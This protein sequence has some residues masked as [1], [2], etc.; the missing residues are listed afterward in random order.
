[1]DSSTPKQYVYPV[2]ATPEKCL[3]C[4]HQTPHADELVYC[5]IAGCNCDRTSVAT[6][7]ETPVSEAT[8]Q[9]IPAS[10]VAELLADAAQRY[11]PELER[12]EAEAYAN[13]RWTHDA[14]LRFLPVSEDDG[15]GDSF[16]AMTK[17]REDL[18]ARNAYR[19]GPRRFGRHGIAFFQSRY[20]PAMVALS[21]LSGAPV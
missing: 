11:C 8:E 4:G 12:V 6:E 14:R 3:D 13:S 19:R 21:S 5:E 1:M 20:A 18:A 7:P 15:L 2:I 10:L 9:M 17:F 16:P